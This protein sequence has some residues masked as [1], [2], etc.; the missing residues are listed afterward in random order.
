MGQTETNLYNSKGQLWKHI[1]FKGQTNEMRYD[2]FGRRAT[3]FWFAHGSAYPS[4]STEY[5]YDTFGQLTNITE[6]SGS[7]AS[8]TYALL[9]SRNR[10]YAAVSEP[11]LKGLLLCGAS[12]L[13][14]LISRVPSEVAGVAT[15]LAL[16]TLAALT[17]LWR[18]CPQ[19]LI[20]TVASARCHDRLPF[21]E[22]F[23]QFV[24]LFP[25]VRI[26]VYSCALV[27]KLFVRLR[28]FL[29]PSK[30]VFIRGYLTPSGVTS[31]TQ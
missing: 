20:N 13:C 21:G 25:P 4:N 22:L 19:L 1:D 8:S 3:N 17:L 5:Y 31:L 10:H 28:A 12:R 24:S 23:Q 29:W 27:V 14:G 7:D 11:G 26:R 18:M 30:S 15:G 9:S 16:V 6:R 2:R